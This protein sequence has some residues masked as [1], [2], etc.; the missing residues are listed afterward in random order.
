MRKDFLLIADAVEVANGKL[1]VLG[2]GWDLFHAPVYPT[3]ARIGL[4]VGIIFEAHELDRLHRVH[5]NIS[6][7]GGHDLLPP[8]EVEFRPQPRT[9]STETVRGIIGLNPSLQIPGAG[10]YE[11]KA[12]IGEWQQT[13]QFHAVL[14]DQRNRGAENVSGVPTKE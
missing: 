2:G 7:V 8:I 3:I 9:I 10:L 12:R 4:A 5:I 13:Q 11:V 1:Y 14:I 6:E